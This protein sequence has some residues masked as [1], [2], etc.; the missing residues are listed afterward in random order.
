MLKGLD[1]F[2]HWSLARSGLRKLLFSLFSLGRDEK[3]SSSQEGVLAHRTQF[4]HWFAQFQVPLLEFLYG[5][6]HDREWAADLVQETFLKAY[7]SARALSSIT[8]PQA[9]LYRIAT[10]TAISALRR[11]RQF[12]WMPFEASEEATLLT[13]LPLPVWPMEDF[14][15]RVAERDAVWQILAELPIRW[16]AILLLQT[17]A[18]MSVRDIATQ[19]QISEANARK[20][21]FRAKERFREL[22]RQR[23][24]ENRS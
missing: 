2:D 7:Q 24:G 15:T 13:L 3:P 20:T 11:H 14:T 18:E 1:R 19:M 22:H 4:A 8:Y 10:N 21:L 5:M 23:E 16:R 9:W 12:D 17:V 6:T